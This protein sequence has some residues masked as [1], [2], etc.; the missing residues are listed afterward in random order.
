M[1][2]T[3]A[4][5]AKRTKRYL[6]KNILPLDWKQGIQVHS[7]IDSIR[8]NTKFSKKLLNRLDTREGKEFRIFVQSVQQT[9]T[10][11]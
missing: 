2:D 8:C 5:S 4:A 10:R 11:I 6:K 9:T 7:R 1:S 3:K